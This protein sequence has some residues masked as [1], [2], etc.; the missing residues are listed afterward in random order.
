MQPSMI[1]LTAFATIVGIALAA[2][3]P[4]GSGRKLN[5]PAFNNAGQTKG[6]EIWRVENF[7]PVAVPKA[8]YGKFYTGDSYIIL[9]TNEDKNKKKSHDVHFWLGLKTTQDEAGSAAI[10][11]VQLDDL[12]NGLPVQHREVEGSE[13]DLFLK[14]FKGGVRYL[15]GGVASGFKHVETNAAKPTRLFQVKGAKNIRLRQVELSVSAMNKGDCY[16]LDADRDVFVYVGPKANRVEKLKAINVANEIRDQDHN[17]RA[18]VHIVDEFS[19]LTD[20]EE[21][22]KKLGSGSPSLVP[23]PSAAK[24]DA[25]FERA[26]ADRVA[27]YKVSDSKGGK[28]TVEQIGTKPLKQ[29]M[30]KQDDSFILD[31]GSGLYVWIGKGATKQEKTESLMKAQEFIKTKKYPAWTPVERIIQNGETAPF[32]HFFQ[33]W[34]N[35]GDAGSRLV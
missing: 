16:I 13:S 10:L 23:E 35:P 9:N 4:S 30:L 34:R 32:K 21:F 26:D 15:E 1:R 20:Q 25:A 28:L 14:Y 29:D 5:I 33:T 12:L 24:E 6:L 7:Q 19:S 8:E 11:S 18:T 3:V 22:F 2:T 31:T 17:G 27:L